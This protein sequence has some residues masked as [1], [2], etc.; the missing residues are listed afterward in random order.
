MRWLW[1]LTAAAA[2][3]GAV[4][5][6]DP[7]GSDSSNGTSARFAWRTFSRIS[8]ASLGAG[9]YVLL[10]RGATWTEPLKITASGA[11]GAPVTIG[12]YGSGGRPVIDGSYLP[13][14]L[15]G[16]LLSGDGVEQVVISGIELRSS[17]RHGINFYRS[18]GITLRDM[19]VSGSRGDGMLFFE[20]NQIVVEDCDVYGNSLDLSE[21]NAG[22]RIDGREG[23]YFSFLIRGCRIHENRGG[24]EWASANGIALGHT[25]SGFPTLRSVRIDSNEIWANGN[26]N[27]NQAGRGIT[28]SVH[29]DIT[30]TRNSV[31]DNASAGIYL[32]DYGLRF[33]A[34]IENNVFRNNAL[35]QFGGFTEGGA[36]ARFNL[37]YVDDAEITGMGVEVGGKGIWTLERNVF[38]YPVSSNDSWRAFIRLNDVWQDAQFRSDRNVFYSAGPRRWKRADGVAVGFP[39]WQA[40]GYDS[41]STA[42][43]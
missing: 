32:G 36:L 13:M 7:S 26:P 5:Y 20:C 4:Y 21:S 22:I 9:D 33:D 11:A 30:I 24:E 25:G 43:R 1:M 6:V 16:A 14:S 18:T 41:N 2:A 38:A 12:A 35:R 19:A 37:L 39:Q 10:K 31:H 29:G 42:P 23:I 28:A 3:H 17:A 15:D 8:Q 40:S 34:L 27:Q